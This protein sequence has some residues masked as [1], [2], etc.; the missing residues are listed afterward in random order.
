VSTTTP[1]STGK[2]W[3][4]LGVPTYGGELTYFSLNNVLTFD[5][6]MGTANTSLNMGW[7]DC[8]FT[9]N[10]TVDPAT[11]GFNMSFRPP[12]YVSGCLATSWEFSDPSTIVIHLR[13]GVHFQ[14]ISPVNGREFT[15]DDVVYHYGRMLGIAAGFTTVPTFNASSPYINM[16]GIT[17]VDKYTV[18]CKWKVSNPEYIMETMQASS[19]IN[20]IEAKEAVQQ[21]GDLNDWHHAMGTGPFTL[22]DFVSS[23]SMT[24]VKNPNY[25]G[26]DERYPANKLPY[27]DSIKYLII[28]N[29]DTALAGLRT[30]K[31]DF[32][33][34]P[35]LQQVQ[36]VQKTNPEMLLVT[37]PQ[38]ALDIDPR[39]DMAPF[40][41]I[42]VRIALQKSLDLPT[43]AA[44][45]YGGKVPP[46]PSSLVSNYMT[47]WGLPY[48]E[49]PQSLKDEYSYDP[50]AAKKLL[51]DAGFPNGFDTT[52]V[53]D[54]SGDL[55]VIQ[56][57]LSYFAKIGVNVAVTP[58]DPAAINTYLLTAHKNT[59]LAQR[60]TGLLGRTLAPLRVLTQFQ[61]G[62]QVNYE[63][64][65]DPVFNAFYPA[66]MAAT[67]V[68]GMK[69]VVK[70][71]CLYVAQKH[72]LISLVTPNNYTLY[73]PWLHGY[74]GQNT[75]FVTS[76]NLY[77][78][79]FWI[80]QK[81]KK[82]M[83]R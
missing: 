54:S 16:T 59:G 42:R 72:I 44:T 64:W 51:A 32:V 75:A 61:T 13:Q 40:T 4:K 24:L 78:A 58:M 67:T 15:S 6:I 41:D 23:A 26:Y 56:I 80:D 22:Q 31:I 53:V 27:V 70:D 68:D 21:W 28:N 10:W 63:M 55:D 77:G 74:S 60:S 34:Q 47:G 82:S 71:A 33:N 69:Q 83:G 46:Y 9:D 12:E 65:S 35:T 3:D 73:Q 14:N 81:L 62:D 38:N 43:I 11:F 52:L 25:W 18:S 48:P 20:C 57:V 37:A 39:D 30:G 1:S 50:A 66:A 76:L 19:I 45:Y 17:A 29:R 8:L 5:P 2:W 49:W 7:Q 36:S 79:R